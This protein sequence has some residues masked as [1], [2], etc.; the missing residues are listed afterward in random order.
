MTDQLV[1]SETHDRTAVLTLNR[2]ES[3][4]ALNGPVLQELTAAMAAADQDDAVDAIVL[5]G[6][7]PAFCAGIDLKAVAAQDPHLMRL[8]GSSL[9]RA[10]AGDLPNRS[11]A[12]STALRSPA[13]SRSHCTATS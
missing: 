8:V 2:P 12:P 9:A 13:G 6:A 11:S 4:N 5:T 10:V 3:R 7:G 1:R